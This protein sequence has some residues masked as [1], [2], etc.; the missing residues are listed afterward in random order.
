MD[1]ILHHGLTDFSR[2]ASLLSDPG[3]ARMLNELMR[4]IALTPT[5]LARCANLSPSSTSNHLGILLQNGVLEVL[6]QGRHRYYRLASSAIAHAIEALAVAASTVDERRGH[7]IPSTPPELRAA[8]SCYRHLAGRL[9]VTLFE[10]L[11]CRGYLVLGDDQRVT[12]TECGRQWLTGIL[13]IP[14]KLFT[15][16]KTPPFKPCLDWSERRF[17]VAGPAAEHMFAAMIEFGWLERSRGRAV[18]LTE[19]GLNQLNI[20]FPEHINEWYGC[21]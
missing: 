14:K 11:Q 5:E 8:R 12:T 10:V 17:H 20:S 3:R 21:K 13:G 19:L 9:G 2:L 15:S 16:P 7:F 6:Q 1:Q 4:G 18:R